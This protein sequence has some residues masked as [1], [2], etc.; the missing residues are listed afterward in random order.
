M[1]ERSVNQA[2]DDSG[3]QPLDQVGHALLNRQRQTDVEVYVVVH[4]ERA[5]RED[6]DQRSKGG[7]RG[8]PRRARQVIA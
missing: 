8:E 7:S 4:D 6:G 5:H 2:H 1:L 3:D